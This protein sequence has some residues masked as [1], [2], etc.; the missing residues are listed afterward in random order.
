MS[1]SFASSFADEKSLTDAIKRLGDDIR[2]KKTAGDDVASL[3]P[4]LKALK[5]QYEE[6][7]GTP[8]DPPKENKKKKGGAATSQQ[9]PPPQK[10][11]KDS[12]GGDEGSEN[13]RELRA[14]RLE[15]VSV[16]QEAGVN[17]FEYTFEATHSAAQLAADF[18]DLA[19]G[20]EATDAAVALAG[21][22]MTRRVFGKLA[23]FTMQDESGTYQLYLD[24]ARMLDAD[25]FKNIKAWTD[26]GDIVGAR[27]T[28]CT[29]TR[30]GHATG[31]PRD[32]A[33]GR[34]AERACAG[35][36]LCRAAGRPRDRA[37]GRQAVRGCAAICLGRAE[38]RPRDC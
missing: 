5:S 13:P 26:A 24:K 31:R 9:Q 8:F 11:K 1:A 10:K 12:G 37:G 19:P 22:V 28:E 15:K 14:A 25:Q 2:A 7:T 33:G 30:L 23:F 21:R 29:T 18:A 17:P 3:I 20:S 38:G 36:R 34:Q 16:M 6:M 35:I 32:R 27:G 4:E